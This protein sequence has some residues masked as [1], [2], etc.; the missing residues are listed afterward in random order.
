M[1]ILAPSVFD[2]K[3]DHLCLFLLSR[4]DPSTHRVPIC[5]SPRFDHNKDHVVEWAQALYSNPKTKAYLAGV[6]VHW[7]GGLNTQNLQ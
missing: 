3:K 1:P 4:L 6:G 2:H 5:G 7:Y